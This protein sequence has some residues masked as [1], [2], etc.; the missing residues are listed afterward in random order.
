MTNLDANPFAHRSVLTFELPDFAAIKE[1]HYLPAFYAG[2]TEQLGEIQVILDTHGVP[3][4]ENTIVAMEKSGQLLMRTLS[5]FYNK[6][7]SDTNDAL[8]AIEEEL[9]PKLAAHQDKIQLNPVLFARIKSLFDD[10]ENLNLSG[11][12]S[13]LLERYYMDLIHAGAHL[14]DTERESLKQLNEKLSILETTFS[15]NVLA[16]TND[17]AVLVDSLVELDGLS[18]NEIT[19]AGNAARD[20]GQ[21]GKW[22]INMVNF[23]G[24]PVLDSLTNRELRKKIMQ[25]SLLKANR[26]NAND[27]KPVLLEMIRLRAERAELFGKSTHA[28]HVISIQ[29]AKSPE[30]VHTMLKKMAPAAMRN[31][32]LEAVD[33]EKSAG[34]AIESWDWGFY[35]EQVRLEKFNIDTSK[36]RPYFELERVLHDGVFFAANKLFGITFKERTDLV[37]YHPEAR[38]FEVSNEDGTPLGLF[39][40]D[41]FTRDSKRGG[42]WMNSLVDQN[43]LLSQLPVVVNNLNIPKPPAGQPALLTLDFTTTLFHEFG[44]ALH[45]LLSQVKYPRVSGTSVQRDF[46]EFP[47]QVNE[48]WIMWPE[49]LNNYARH[50]ETGELMP[51]EWVDS[52]NAAS[53][54]NEG[55]STTSYLAAAVLDLA[56][57]SLTKEEAVKVNDVEAFEAKALA[58]YGLDFEPVPTRYRSTYFSH[59]FA[60]GYSAGYYG[61]VWSEVLDA[62]TVDWF[63]E[64]GGL[65]RK[66]GEHFRDTL[67][68]RGGSIDSMQMF[69]NFRGRDS[70]IEPLLKRRGLL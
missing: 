4:F 43:F 20:R 15:K 2:C 52:L 3:T 64:N 31:A 17:L 10:R 55:F 14:T 38:A 62:D 34:S 16:D 57:H 66:N 61:Y 18:D 54:F 53:T 46:V 23:T 56:W 51:Q 13:W 50:F 65:L 32:K 1:E 26:P 45:G 6:S 29:T 35:T 41:F 47:S 59:I 67:L 49:V 11:E 25:E 70:K 40:G 5:V 8:D 44:H 42:A 30:N 39:I 24:N 28:E 36:M 21:E 19:A 68:G 69:R 7:S 9:A 63:K 58:D 27:N 37:T 22:L 33:L 12:D 60:G 48:M